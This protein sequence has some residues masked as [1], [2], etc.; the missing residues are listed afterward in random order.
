MKKKVSTVVVVDGNKFLI[1]QRSK[2]SSGAGSWNFPGGSVEKDEGTP[3][4][5]CR[6]LFEEA[7]LECD[8]DDLEYIGKLETRYL[9]VSFYITDRFSGEVKINKESQDYKWVTL[10]ESDKYNFVSGG[11]LHPDLVFEIGKFIYGG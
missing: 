4:A 5:A 1:L 2:T 10:S 8:P 3:Q 9:D 6:E 7:G 11:D